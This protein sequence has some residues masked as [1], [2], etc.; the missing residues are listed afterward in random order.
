MNQCLIYCQKCGRAIFQLGLSHDYAGPTCSCSLEL[1]RN[2]SET[3]ASQ[4]FNDIE[5]LLLRVLEKLEKLE[6]KE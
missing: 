1:M 2:C 3:E 4:R 5:R 6:K